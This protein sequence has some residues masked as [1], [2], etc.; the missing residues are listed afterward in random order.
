ME[1]KRKLERFDLRIPAKI[2]LVDLSQDDRGEEI[3]DLTTSDISSGGAFF[4]T[5]KPLPKG[6]DIKI[7]L[8][9][10]LG[11]LKKLSEDSLHALI[12]VSGTVIR[13]ES[14]GMAISFDRNYQIRPV[15]K[16]E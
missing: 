3:P 8:I 4:H 11:K 15:K 13:T 10:P 5:T 12:E 6:T 16:D 9:L 14:E 1:E 7:D 2:K